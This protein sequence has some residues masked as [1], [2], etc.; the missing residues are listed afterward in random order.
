MWIASLDEL[1]AMGCA[2]AHRNLSGPEWERYLPGEPYRATCPDLPHPRSAIE[3]LVRQGKVKEALA[4]FERAGELDPGLDIVPRAEVARIQGEELVQQARF[5]QALAALDRA[6]K[7]DPGLAEPVAGRLASVG[8]E[9]ADREA[10]DWVL[11]LFARAVELDAG[12]REE[13]ARQLVNV[14]W[15]YAERGDEEQVRALYARAIEWAAASGDPFLIG[16]VC[17]YGREKWLAAEA[18]ASTC[19]PLPQ[20]TYPI[21]FTNVRINDEDDTFVVQAGSSFTVTLDYRI[22]DENCSDCVN[23]ILVGLSTGAPQ[24]CI[25]GGIPEAGGTEG[26]AAITMQAPDTPGRY[27]LGFD[28]RQRT[29]YCP[30]DW[31]NSPPDVG[32]QFATIEVK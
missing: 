1:V 7:L 10:D 11:P 21:A 17:W 30:R 8:R 22:V 19:D 23:W 29:Y 18:I 2:Q 9:A 24:G 31:W 27:A 6:V 12:L 25:Y 13:V 16:H 26:S 14:G 4:A 20:R 15:E 28:R 5:K 32:R 3:A